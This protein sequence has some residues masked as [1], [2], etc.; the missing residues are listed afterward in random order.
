M[1]IDKNKLTSFDDLF[2]INSDTKEGSN[3]KNI[4]IDEIVPSPKNPFKVEENGEMDQLVASIKENGIIVPLILRDMGNGKYD[5]IAGHRRL[6]ASKIAGLSE[7][8]AD[9]R[10][11]SDEEADIIMVDTNLNREHISISEKA[12]A[13]KL[14]YEAIK[15]KVGRNWEE[16]SNGAL[17]APLK[18]SSE[19]VA[20][21][22]G[23]SARTINNYLCLTE[24]V[25]L[26][27]DMI[28]NKELTIK[29]GVQ[30][31]Y[32]EK[33]VQ[34]HVCDFLQREE[35]ILSEE[36]AKLLR[37]AFEG[38][39]NIELSNIYEILSQN[40]SD[41]PDIPK[42]PKYKPVFKV[43]RKARKKYFPAEY[44]EHDIENVIESL[45]ENWAR[46]HNPS[47]GEDRGEYD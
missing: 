47:F 24:L 7:V 46:E 6:M 40:S 28:D 14:K 2:G 39:E 15:R 36:Q 1:V 43:S 35:V 4:K 41:L 21:E 38:I 22:M 11:L 34:D 18:R 29:T 45:L 5:L 13:C 23:V 19:I 42:Q 3:I 10:D 8:P 44:D 30:L 17:G 31:S 33:G 16:E 20:D 12:F 9:V 25:P 32:L 27:L 37:D 26:L